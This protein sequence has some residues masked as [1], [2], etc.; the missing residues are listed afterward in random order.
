MQKFTFRLE[1]VRNIKIAIENRTK[2]EFGL[3]S[4]A[5]Y[6]EIEK[7]DGLY[8]RKSYYQG[9]LEKLCEDRLDVQKLKECRE[10]ITVLDEKITEQKRVVRR[11]ERAVEEARLKL[12]EA[13]RERKTLDR[14][15]ENAFEEYESELRR[16]EQN[17]I[18][19]FV[20]YRGSGS[21]R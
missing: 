16:S 8:N 2:N 7:L 20:S 19:E 1:N 18:D 11:C 5:L 10:A 21:R 9:K 15:R 3:A 17:E 4:A 6:K 13:M 12:N 14:L